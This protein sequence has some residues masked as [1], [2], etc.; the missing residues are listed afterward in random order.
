MRFDAANG[1]VYHILH[2]LL[3]FTVSGQHGVENPPSLQQTPISAP[4]V[5]QIGGTPDSFG[6]GKYLHGTNG[7]LLF[8]KTFLRAKPVMNVTRLIGRG[9]QGRQQGRGGGQPVAT[10]GNCVSRVRVSGGGGGGWGPGPL[11]IDSGST[12]RVGCRRRGLPR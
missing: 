5:W 1:H 7:I 6:F 8:P 4:Y 9:Q 3:V 11:F 2:L 12:S 10:C